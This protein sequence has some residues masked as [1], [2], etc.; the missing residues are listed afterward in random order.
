MQRTNLEEAYRKLERDPNF[1]NRTRAQSLEVDISAQ[2]QDKFWTNSTYFSFAVMNPQLGSSN[3]FR[4]QLRMVFLQKIT[5]NNYNKSIV[6]QLIA[7][8]F[9]TMFMSWIQG[10]KRG[11]SMVLI[12]IRLELVLSFRRMSF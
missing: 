1:Q 5:F 10:S 7:A 2:I 11:R 4:D 3:N 8:P 12:F 9:Y 6:L